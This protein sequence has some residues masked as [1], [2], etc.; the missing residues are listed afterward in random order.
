MSKYKNL[1]AL[2]EKINETVANRVAYNQ[3]DYTLNEDLVG[4]LIDEAIDI[5]R[6]WRKTWDSDTEFLSGRFD[7]NIVGYVMESLNT[8]G[9]EGQSYESANGNTKQYKMSP[10]Q[11]LCSGIPQCL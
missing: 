9:I 1:N 3:P 8:I 7:S 4:D 2:R 10:R 11:R 6:D 5:I